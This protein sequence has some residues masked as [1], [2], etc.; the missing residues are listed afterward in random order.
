M[1][2]AC[3][4]QENQIWNQS[5]KQLWTTMWV[6]GTKLG[7]STGP[8][9]ILNCWA[10][11]AVLCV[12]KTNRTGERMRTAGGSQQRW[13]KC[14]NEYTQSPGLLEISLYNQAS[15]T[16]MPIKYLLCASWILGMWVMVAHTFTPSRSRW[17]SE[18]ESRLV[19]STTTAKAA[20]RNPFWQSQNKQVINFSRVRV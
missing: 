19:Y 7:S 18:F 16:Y 9:N 15:C 1:P 8:A 4:E 12:R 6:L 13:R 5:Y 2:G 17:V 20:E 14:K 11:L 10:N 3:R